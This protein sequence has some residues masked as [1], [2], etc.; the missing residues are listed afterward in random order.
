MKKNKFIKFLNK[1]DGMFILI[2]GIIVLTFWIYFSINFIVIPK[3]YGI[4]EMLT[5]EGLKLECSKYTQKEVLRYNLT[6]EYNDLLYCGTQNID[7]CIEN[8]PKTKPK[9][10]TIISK[11]EKGKCSNGE[12]IKKDSTIIKVNDKC[13]EWKIVKDWRMI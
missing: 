7:D 9:I 13:V 2:S 8:A 4:N 3:S 1:Y 12:I 10:K 5:D 6:C 11:S